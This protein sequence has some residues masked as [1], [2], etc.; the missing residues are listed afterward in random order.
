VGFSNFLC[1][2]CLVSY[3]HF[4]LVFY[5][6]NEKG[7]E[8]NLRSLK[9]GVLYL[10]L[11]FVGVGLALSRA[12]PALLSSLKGESINTS[13]MLP[14]LVGGMALLMLSGVCLWVFGPRRKK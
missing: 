14:Y 12:I 4:L 10:V 1:P 8:M 3:I 11:G 2:V 6:L 9:M 5:S 13:A 7:E